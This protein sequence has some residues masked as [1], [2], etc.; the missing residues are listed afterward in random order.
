MCP[1]RAGGGGGADA[2]VT[3]HMRAAF[4][5]VNGMF[6][7]GERELDG[8]AP[9]RGEEAAHRCPFPTTPRDGGG[10]QLRE[11]TQYVTV[12]CSAAS[13]GGVPRLSAPSPLGFG[14]REDTQFFS[15][16]DARAWGDSTPALAPR[17]GPSGLCPG[18][19][20]GDG[21]ELL[22]REDTCCVAAVDAAVDDGRAAGV[23]RRI[24]L[25]PRGMDSADPIHDAPCG[26]DDA[27]VRRAPRVRR[28]ES[29][30][31][32]MQENVM[33]SGNGE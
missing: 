25:A 24:V 1:P 12:P 9:M 21:S 27:V 7:G 16:P 5:A 14:I 8:S 28:R 18:A 23:A 11:D 29:M 32:H 33:A 13:D 31:A 10:L 4:E 30:A 2:T 17:D 20:A 19:R 22:I 15:K 3:L 6:G 26:G